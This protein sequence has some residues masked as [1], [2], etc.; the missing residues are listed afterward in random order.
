MRNTISVSVII[1]AMIFSAGNI[2]ATGNESKKAKNNCDTSTKELLK[3]SVNDFIGTEDSNSQEII[4]IES[5]KTATP[6]KSAVKPESSEEETRTKVAR[7][8]FKQIFQNKR[9]KP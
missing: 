8:S 5:P 1:S 4:S 9:S 7:Y 2:S 6:Q 3:F